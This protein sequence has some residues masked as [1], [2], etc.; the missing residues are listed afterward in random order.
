MIAPHIILR[1]VKHDELINNI[2]EL[3]KEMRFEI[4]RLPKDE[5]KPHWNNYHCIKSYTDNSHELI[6]DLV[7]QLQQLPSIES[8]RDMQDTIRKQ[9]KYIEQLGGNNT[10]I[11][12]IKTLDI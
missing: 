6:C 9:R 5:Q 12:Y 11:G 7:E 4:I 10:I 8:F 3:L 1:S 2:D